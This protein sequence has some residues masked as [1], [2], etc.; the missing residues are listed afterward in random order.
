MVNPNA[1]PSIADRMA[2]RINYIQ[3]REEGFLPN[4]VVNEALSKSQEA[5]KS[6]GDQLSRAL[7]TRNEE[8]QK[9]LRAIANDISNENAL[10]ASEEQVERL[11]NAQTELQRIHG[12]LIDKVKT[13][14]TCL[15]EQLDYKAILIEQLNKVKAAAKKTFPGPIGTK[16]LN[17]GGEMCIN[18]A[19]SQK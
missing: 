14:E 13:G 4:N 2:G 17:T 18:F 3:M 5:E 7:N 11:R 9:T 19:K 10:R 8:V 15:Q 6:Y 16:I 1:R 12:T